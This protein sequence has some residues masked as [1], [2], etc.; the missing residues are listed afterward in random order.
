M[1]Y[2]REFYIT[3]TV[4]PSMVFVE[5]QMVGSKLST[6]TVTFGHFKLFS[7]TAFLQI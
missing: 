6:F 4:P 5:A 3:H 7:I 1:N 2:M